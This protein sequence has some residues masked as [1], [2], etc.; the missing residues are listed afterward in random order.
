MKTAA[1]AM[2]KAGPRTEKKAEVRMT[3]IIAAD[4]CRRFRGS[5]SGSHGQKPSLL[6]LLA[7]FIEHRTKK[8]GSADYKTFTNAMG[9]ESVP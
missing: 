8:S 7:N 5:V 4:G 6:C 1:A 2:L 3:P 9:Q